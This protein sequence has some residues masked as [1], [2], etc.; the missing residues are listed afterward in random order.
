MKHT[1]LALRLLPALT[2][3]TLLV[4]GCGVKATDIPI[5]GTYPSGETFSVRIEFG[6]VLNLPDRAKVIADGVEVGML[7][8]I[9]LIGSTAVATVQIKSDAKLPKTTMAELRQS[10]ILGDI[11][12]ALEAPKNADTGF[13]RNGDVIPVSQT[14]AAT[15]VEDILRA[16]SNIITGGRWG[17]MQ[18]LISDVN[19]AFPAD[20]AELDRINRAGRAALA[21]MAGH[22]A[23]LDSILASA[24]QISA[25]LEAG[26]GSVDTILTYGPARAAGLSDVLLNVV[27]LIISGGGLAGNAGELLLPHVGDFHSIVR[28]LA[29]TALTI[30]YS[31]ITLREN[32]DAFY[33]LLR[34]KLIPFL[35]APD[36]RVRGVA[37]D[38]QADQLVTTLRSIGMVP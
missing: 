25:K 17:D 1:R 23:E 13:L 5:P 32:T 16:L 12:I 24:Q 34:E 14:V 35:N 30:A 9:D 18:Q 7:D 22:T 8:H 29:P 2:A 36:V 28:V 27:K 6:S 26:R 11:H 4:S 3:V 31:D 19:A 33:T 10:T 20:P 15:N 21:D 37:A 38:V